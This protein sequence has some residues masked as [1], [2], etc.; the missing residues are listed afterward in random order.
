MIEYAKLIGSFL[1]A[2]KRGRAKDPFK[3]AIKCLL[4][5]TIKHAIMRLCIV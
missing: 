4:H 2:E 5:I 1:P 3:L